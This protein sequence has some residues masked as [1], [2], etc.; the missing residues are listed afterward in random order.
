M[1]S[2]RERRRNEMENEPK[3]IKSALNS[4]SNLNSNLNDGAGVRMNPMPPILMTRTTFVRFTV[5]VTLAG[6]H[7][8]A[9]HCTVA[10]FPRAPVMGRGGNGKK[11]EKKRRCESLTERDGMSNRLCTINT[12]YC[13][14]YCHLTW[15]WWA[16]WNQS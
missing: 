14:K 9:L 13:G 3:V 15:S 1:E 5:R 6:W 7:L 11:G 16:A 10:T 12:C 2:N 4:N 8:C